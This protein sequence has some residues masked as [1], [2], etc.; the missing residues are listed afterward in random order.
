[1]IEPTAVRCF[2]SVSATG[3]SAAVGLERAPAIGREAIERRRR[4]HPPTRNRLSEVVDRYAEEAKAA[5]NAFVESST[6]AV[7]N[8]RQRP[9]D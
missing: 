6:P 2:R 7:R 5:G 1:M 8:G 3:C 9:L 4:K